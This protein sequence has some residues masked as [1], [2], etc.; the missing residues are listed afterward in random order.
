MIKE[1]EELEKR[2]LKNYEKRDDFGIIQK[3]QEE[4]II[5]LKKKNGVILEK[6]EN[7]EKKLKNLENEKKVDLREKEDLKKYI[8]D[9]KIENYNSLQKLEIDLKNKI[10]IQK[11]QILQNFEKSEKNENLSNLNLDDFENENFCE[12]MSD[13]INLQKLRET[14]L[15]FLKRNSNLNNFD[16]KLSKTE[17]FQKGRESQKLNFYDLDINSNEIENS[18]IFLFDEKIE[19]KNLE[20]IKEKNEIIFKL[21]QEILDLRNLE[22]KKEF[23]ILDLR[24]FE[25]KNKILKMEILHL[26]EKILNLEKN[27]EKKKNFFEKENED[28]LKIFLSTKSDLQYEILQRDDLILN[29][30]KEIPKLNFTIKQYEKH[31]LDMNKKFKRN[32]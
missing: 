19:K 2:L 4:L 32:K 13:F 14:R 7:L 31:I 28:L 15:T 9:L 16:N 23:E 22:K 24:N 5:D 17:N 27:F 30:K 25:E 29:L 26:N 1:R 12:R 21:R 10:K 20:E 11:S 8:S 18:E 3:V 6:N